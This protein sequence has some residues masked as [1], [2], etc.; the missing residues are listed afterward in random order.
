MLT[1]KFVQADYGDSDNIYFKNSNYRLYVYPDRRDIG[2]EGNPYEISG[3]SCLDFVELVHGDWKFDYIENMNTWRVE[4]GVLS[5][6]VYV[7]T[8]AVVSHN[9]VCQSN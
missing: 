1:L 9:I 7:R 2:M 6:T 8:N 5:W 3:N 4:K